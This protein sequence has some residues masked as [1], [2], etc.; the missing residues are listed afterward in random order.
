[1]AKEVKAEAKTKETGVET[2]VVKL[3]R[4]KGA[5]D[6]VFASV[7]NYTCFIKRGENVE[8]PAYIAEVLEHS[9][10]MQDVIAETEAANTYED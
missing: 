3:P 8:V 9:E 1:M 10:R 4:I 2:V 7:N 6:P 5:E